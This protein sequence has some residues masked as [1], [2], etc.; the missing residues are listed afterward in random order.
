V[1]LNTWTSI[2]LLMLV[3]FPSIGASSA[4]AAAVPYYAFADIYTAFPGP[5]VLEEADREGRGPLS[6]NAGGRWFCETPGPGCGISI[7]PGARLAYGEVH[8][9][10]AAGNL[11]SRAGSFA[12]VETS[13]FVRTYGY[14]SQTFRVVS[15]G[16]LAPGAPVGLDLNMQFSGL[17]DDNGISAQAAA[18]MTV[19]S[20]GPVLD[21]VD[22]FGAALDYM[23]VGTFEDVFFTP[24]YLEDAL[25]YR[26]YLGGPPQSPVDFDSTTSFEAAV[27]DVLFL[28]AMIYLTNNLGPVPEGPTDSW[29]D[30]SSTLASNLTVVTAG[31]SLQPIPLPPTIALMACAVSALAPL[32][33]R[34]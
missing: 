10:P 1:N 11:E 34:R 15:D 16:T 30:F 32:R 28:E 14:L 26:Q 23:P 19:L 31:A 33:R 6:L 5:V 22:P 7:A 9:D 8:V 18:L 17:I 25:A 21:Y 27:G 2:R 29:T 3:V 13:G 24:E 20:G 12:Y 4:Y